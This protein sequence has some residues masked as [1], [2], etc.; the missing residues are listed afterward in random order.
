V[1]LLPAFAVPVNVGVVVVTVEPFAG[2]VMYKLRTPGVGDGPEVGV[3]V[4]LTADVGAGVFVG[5]GVGDGP[6]VGVIVEPVVGVG[7]GVPVWSC[8][9][10]VGIGEPLPDMVMFAGVVPISELTLPSAMLPTN[11]CAV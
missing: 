5:I 2:Y 9:V 10:G 7:V 4:G 8:C 1:I 3:G 6:A 11:V